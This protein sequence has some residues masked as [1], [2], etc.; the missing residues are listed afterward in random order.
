MS[1]KLEFCHF[2]SRIV[3]LRIVSPTSSSQSF[4][5]DLLDAGELEA[6]IQLELREGAR[7]FLID[8][9]NVV[10]IHSRAFWA[11]VSAGMELEKQDGLVV[12]AGAPSS[13]LHLVES[14]SACRALTIVPDSN[15]GLRLLGLAGEKGTWV[16]TVTPPTEP[17]RTKPVRSKR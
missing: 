7:G 15:A 8:L 3:G 2:P 9:K 17:V 10:Y 1:I 11:M 13:L 5:V 14:T 4:D 12:L 16:E 6:R